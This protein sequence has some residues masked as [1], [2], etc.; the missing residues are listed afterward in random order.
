MPVAKRKFYIYKNGRYYE[1][2]FEDANIAYA[3][4]ATETYSVG[5][6][7]IYEGALYKC[8]TAVS[9]A[10]AFDSTK[11][12]EVK[13]SYL[14]DEK[15]DVLV[16]GTNIKTINNTSLLG[17]GDVAIQSTLVSGTN[18]KTVN[19]TS[20]LGS[21][22]VAVQPT[23]VSGT[24]IKTI[25]ST[26]L[27]GS[28]DISITASDVGAYSQSEIDAKL[29]SYLQQ[30]DLPYIP[31][32]TSDLTNN[33]GFLA[34]AG[35]NP[36]RGTGGAITQ[37]T[38]EAAISIR[39]TTGAS[40]DVGIFYMSQDNCYVANSSDG[41]YS[42]GVYDTDLT[43]DMS[44]VDDASFIVLS[45]GEG[46][47]IRGSKVITQSDITNVSVGNARC[48]SVSCTWY[49]NYIYDHNSKVLTLSGTITV[50]GEDDWRYGL[51]N[52]ILSACGLSGSVA[53]YYRAGSISAMSASREYGAFL[54]V[55]DW[56][57][58]IVSCGRYYSSDG[59][60]GNW[61]QANNTGKIY[62]NN[63]V[64]KLS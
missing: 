12:D 25:N 36:T 13:V 26:S 61:K 29:R 57:Y 2:S 51:V 46:C 17:S 62:F 49:F 19:S 60:F 28:G 42:F 24:N 39:T 23:L 30:S 63:L 43:S 4:D 10:E 59:A 40:N 8:K 34:S 50:G 32:K 14:L 37:P 44:S 38:G 21:G 9:T 1:G 15:Q 6:L 20:L 55:E 64:I 18:I 41:S 58:P 53:T 3:Y 52:D 31:T 16:S 27:L 11:W 54:V 56:G 22:D 33:S 47:K 5:D 35:S 48:V 7:V 45:G